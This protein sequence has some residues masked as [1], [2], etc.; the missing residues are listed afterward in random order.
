MV[1][2]RYGEADSGGNPGAAAKEFTL[3]RMLRAEGLPVPVAVY[4][5]ESG[6]VFPGPY[7]VTGYVQGTRCVEGTREP[8]PS[9]VAGCVSQMA[10]ILARLHRLRPSPEILTSLP[11]QDDGW[12]PPAGART[13]D[14]G[15][16]PPD[17]ARARWI[18]ESM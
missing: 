16:E 4:L 6:D 8:A 1:V 17:E 10:E 15:G 9:L 7:I 11:R 13:A 14:A 12:T 5:D 3:L 2:H 18:V